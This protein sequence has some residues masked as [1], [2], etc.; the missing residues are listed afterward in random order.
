[1]AYKDVNGDWEVD[2]I[3]SSDYKMYVI[4]MIWVGDH[5]FEPF[6]VLHTSTYRNPFSRTHFED[7]TGDGVS[8]V[9]FD[10]RQ[11]GGGTNYSEHIW[12][13]H[14]IQCQVNSCRFIWQGRYA[15]LIEAIEPSEYALLLSEMRLV[16]SE[17]GYRV[18]QRWE[19]ALEFST[20][21]IL[22]T[23]YPLSVIRS[24]IYGRKFTSSATRY[25]EF[26]WD[27]TKFRLTHQEMLGQAQVIQRKQSPNALSKIGNRAWIKV[28][29][30]PTYTD[31]F[32]K[33]HLYI[34]AQEIGLPFACQ[35][36]F[37]QVEWRDITNDGAEELIVSTLLVQDYDDACVRQW[38]MV[39]RWD[40]ITAT[41]IANIEGC[42]IQSNLYGVRFEDFDNNGQ[43]EILAAAPIEA[44]P[45]DCMGGYCWYE[46]NKFAHLYRWDGKRF[47]FWKTIEQ[48]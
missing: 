2:L 24:N 12:R 38:R 23:F 35:Q 32:Q 48:N 8:E 30:I 34:N 29:P 7:W 19:Y 10:I 14:V 42:V 44:I 3:I 46:L 36:N 39:Y 27:G 16:T 15:A 21:P 45:D 20:Y 41:S 4:I 9:I 18:L 40:G 33:C 31:H 13:K 11:V 17:M 1:M 47:E 43:V 25:S 6:V 26:I 37:T 22:N 5:Y 28:V